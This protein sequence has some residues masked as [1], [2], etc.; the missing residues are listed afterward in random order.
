[1]YTCP[2]CQHN[3]DSRTAENFYPHRTGW[4]IL[5][6]PC[7][8]KRKRDYVAAHREENARRCKL[9]RLRKSCALVPIKA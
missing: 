7:E 2:G 1:M 3:F 6:I 8:R 4:E 5:C 9:Y